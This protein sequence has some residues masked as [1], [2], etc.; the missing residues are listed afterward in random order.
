V[1]IVLV[2]D[3]YQV[4]DRVGRGG[5]GEVWSGRDLVLDRPV[6]V[7]LVDTGRA[8]QHAT[9][10]FA[11][12]VQTA[13]RL[14]DPHVVTVFDAGTSDDKLYLVMELL[15][16]RT[17][18]D[19]RHEHGTLDE[20]RVAAIGAQAAA[21]LATAHQHGVVHRDVKPA[22]LL[23]TDDNRIKVGD[24]GVARFTDETDG[25]LTST[26][27]VVGTTLYLAPERVKGGP[28]SPASDVYAL[29]CVLYELLAGRPVV[30]GDTPIAI[31]TRHLTETPDPLELTD[32]LL[33]GPL[34]ALITS[35]LAKDPAERPTAQAV[36]S[37]L[38]SLTAHDGTETTNLAVPRALRPGGPGTPSGTTRRERRAAE[39]GESRGGRRAAV[40]GGVAATALVVGV[41]LAIGLP[42]GTS[43]PSHGST[44][45]HQATPARSGAR[46]LPVGDQQGADTT[47]ADHPASRSA[48]ASAPAGSPSAGTPSAPATGATG[49][50]PSQPAGSPTPPAQTPTD[51]VPTDV[52]TTPAGTPGATTGAN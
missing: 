27:Q 35:M 6:A 43:D 2:A 31:L 4:T 1:W 15:S 28:A 12:E 38:G 5:M 23:V 24:F 48:S 37:L 22:N 16:G 47:T 44:P 32:P 39:A 51:S 25:S 11:L 41:A 8:G 26:G 52:P 19:E 42:V 21:G 34:S 20:H 30:Y 9:D 18:A 49:S 40:V 46:Q 36:A 10:R 45:T 17:V 14:N 7:K 29:G 50:T 3:R 33:A 13:A